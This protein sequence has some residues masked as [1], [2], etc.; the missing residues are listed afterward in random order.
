MKRLIVLAL[1]LTPAMVRA[2]NP[3]ADE[4]AAP[5]EALAR[6]PVKEITVFKDGHAYVVH[7]GS[8]PVDTTGNVLLDRLPTPV[9]GTFWPFVT[10]KNAK[11]AAVTAGRRRVRVERTALTLRDLIE[12]NSNADIIL[13][14]INLPPYPCKVV[15]FLS[16]SAGEV[17]ATSP[18]GVTDP[19]P[20][21]GNLLLV[22][23]AEGTKAV[24]MERITDVKFLGKFENKVA[25]EEYRN[26]LTLHLNW[27]GKA[28]S[29]TADVGMAYVQ[30]GMRWI[31][32]YRVELDG[33]GKAQVKLQATLLNE[34]ADLDDATVHLVIG[35]PTFRFKE[36]VDPVSLGQQLAQLSPYFESTAQTAYA[37]SNSIMT[38]QARM[39]EVRG[40]RGGGGP[41]AP[42]M[43]P[44]VGDATKTEDL[45]VFT[46]KHVTL[47]K[48]QRM[49]LPVSQF[50]VDYKDVY[51]LDVPFAPPVE[52]RR[53][54]NDAQQAELA[55]LFH[56][57]KVMHRIRMN[58]GSGQPF[59]TAPA[60]ILREGK[61]LAQSMMTYTA[62]GAVTDL[63]VTTAVDV[64]VKKSEKETKRTPNAAHFDGSSFSK[65]E[66]EGSISLT[67]Y[68]HTPVE[69]EV[70]RHVLG[71]AGEAGSDGKAEM[72]NLWEDDDRV[73]SRPYW[74]AYYGW[75]GWWAH[76][77]GIGKFTWNVK[78]ETGK[79]VDLKYAW[80][81]FW[82]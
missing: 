63:D 28:P 3:A 52:L 57:P 40:P 60:L 62:R 73:Y 45:F 58:N 17:E 71:H 35:V 36:T 64:R 30:K 31:P 5:A 70:V 32:N 50:S 72:V 8:M 7:Q 42:D 59:T 6:M 26:L 15:R 22:K 53:Q 39:G 82:R 14:E 33:N 21:K 13:T 75:P 51:V 27:D 49:V 10:D 74:W 79:Q 44:D 20:Q 48:G 29:K 66:L 37:L 68:R 76:M 54:I 4:P 65:I 16:R 77:N 11:L 34:L 1:L 81:Y 38:Q 41:A 61:V 55:K 67:N 78:L 2:E 25:D 19:L 18:P 80:Y 56:S 12:A 9:L 24:S 43:G 46:I 23:T 47:K 69:I